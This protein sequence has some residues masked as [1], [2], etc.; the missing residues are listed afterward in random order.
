MTERFFQ[1]LPSIAILTSIAIATLIY[2]RL[3]LKRFKERIKSIEWC[4]ENHWKIIWLIGTPVQNVWAPVAEELIFRA[5]LIVIF[6]TVSGNAWRGIWISSVFFSLVHYFGHKI[7]LFDVFSAKES[8]ETKTDSLEAEISDIKKREAKR[9][10]ITKFLHPITV[11]PLGILSGYY[12]IKYQSIWASVGIH[13][14]WNLV[15][16]I[17]LVLVVLIVAMAGVGIEEAWHSLKYK[18]RRRR[19]NKHYESSRQ[20]PR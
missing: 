7:T 8:S 20:I 6:S 12:G 14:V 10:R 11:F 2:L 19:I 13:F 4:K 1:F 15:M 3:V 18:L 16:P 17:I 5:P 9:L